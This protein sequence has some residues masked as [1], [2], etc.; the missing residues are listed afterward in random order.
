MTGERG[1]LFV[2]VALFALFAPSLIFAGAG[3]AGVPTESLWFS[4]DPFYAGEQVTVYAPLYNSS[5]YRFRGLVTLSDN[6]TT[7]GSKEFLL[8]PNGASEIVSFPWEATGGEHAFSLVITEGTFFLDN[9]N[10]VDLP[11]SGKTPTEVRR[12]VE[13]KPKVSEPPAEEGVETQRYLSS[14]IPRAIISDT[15]PVLGG[16]E[17]FR[18]DQARRALNTSDAIET[19]IL[20]GVS[21]SATSSVATTTPSKGGWSTL[22]EG[23]AGGDFLRTPW[24][25]AK[26]FFMLIYTFF[27]TNVYAFYILLAFIIYKVVRG[28]FHLFFS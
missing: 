23:L 18:V 28:V 20:S 5:A 14:A 4:K 17:R 13:E 25:Y 24:Q 9:K 6:G 7:I 21:D 22:G 11:V 27:T 10:F 1:Q 16:L 2:A 19:R 26:L 3:N 8:E 15:V 12:F